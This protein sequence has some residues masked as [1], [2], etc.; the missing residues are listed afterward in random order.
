MLLDIQNLNLKFHTSK[1]I[2]HAIRDL[3]FHI[4]EG[5]TLGIVGESGCGKSI[6]N[7]ALMG[8]LPDT[9]ELTADKL[10]FEGK[11]LLSFN[12][13]QWQGIRGSDIAMIFQDPM[14]ALN[15]CFTVGYQIEETLELHRKDLSKEQ[16]KEYVFEL[17]D[18]VGIPA[19]RDRAKS[20]A[21]ELSGGMSQRVMIAGAIACNPKLLIADEPTTA[22]DV[23]IQ[24]QI[25]KLLKDIQEKNNM[26]MILVTH[27]LGVVAENA[28]RIQVMYAGEVIESA[29]SSSVIQSPKHP[30]TKGLLDSLPGN[31]SAGFRTPLSSIAG[32]VPDLRSRP[33]GCQFN[34]RCFKFQDDCSSNRP[35]LNS[36]SHQVSCF[37][38]LSEG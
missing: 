31:G 15:P 27:D 14:T 20:Y 3:S 18:Q 26:A 7:L 4:K 24:D 16:R 5:E 22:L 25:L 29:S 2:L 37:H 6:T 38:P 8:L 10:E 30:Y 23:T 9:A 19:P 1:G 35:S 21:H 34:P 28:D 12:E 11:D 36:D 17:L 13:K 32:M 33:S